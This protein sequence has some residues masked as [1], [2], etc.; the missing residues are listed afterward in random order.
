M[1]RKIYVAIVA[2]TTHAMGYLA[3]LVKREATR[4]AFTHAPNIV[5]FPLKS[6]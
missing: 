3:S 5:D 2:I 6:K 1:Q 4:A